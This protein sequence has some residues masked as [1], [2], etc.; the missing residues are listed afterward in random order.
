VIR[1]ACEET[2]LPHSALFI[3]C[4]LGTREN[5]PREGYTFV[6]RLT[7][8]YARPDSA[9]FDWARFPRSAM[10]RLE[11]RRANGFTQVTYA[12]SDRVPD[13]TYTSYQITGWVRDDDLSDQQIRHFYVLRFSGDTPDFWTAHSDHHTFTVFWASLDNLPEIIYPQ[14]EWL[15]VLKTYDAS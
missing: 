8:V 6:D 3:T 7:T 14:N 15:D 2:G 13:P 4:Y 11:G 1:E 10:V 9:S 5:P 12:E